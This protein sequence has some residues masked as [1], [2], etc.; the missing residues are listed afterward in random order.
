MSDVLNQLQATHTRQNPV[1]VIGY[2]RSGTSLICRL[3][4]RYLKVSFGTESQFIVRYHRRLRRYGDLN[5][6]ANLRR[7]IKDLSAERFFVR[8]QQNWG[9]VF[10]PGRALS[11]VDERSY[12]GVLRAIFQQL[13]EHNGMVRW[14]DKTPEYNDHLPLLRSLFPDAQF[15][16]IVRDG[17]DVALSIRKTHFGPKSAFETASQWSDAIRKIRAF[18]AEMPPDQFFEVRYEDLIRQPADTLEVVADFLG[19]DDRCGSLRDYVRHHI[20]SEVEAANF[21]KWRERLSPRDV[22][23][24]EAVAGAELAQFGYE[25]VFGDAARPVSAAERLCWSLHGG[26][27]RLLLLGHWADNWYRLGVRARALGPNLIRRTR[28]TPRVARGRGKRA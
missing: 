6:D 9:F 3:L 18:A 11:S 23:R 8:S 28:I 2:P 10:D 27:S 7:L 1:Y 15:V 16:H 21:G 22:E 4:R 17:R 24:F 26:T 19:I 20:G 13:A 25:L 12:S 14:G 5:D